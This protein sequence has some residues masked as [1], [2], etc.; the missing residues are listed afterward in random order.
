LATNAHDVAAAVLAQVGPM[1]A[2]R[3]QKLVY[4]SQAWHLALLDKPLFPDTIQAWRDGPVTGTLWDAH[5]RQRNVGVWPAGNPG[6]LDDDSAHVVALVCEVYGGL[7]GDDLSELTHSEL[8]WRNARN[9]VSDEQPSKAV[10]QH[11]AMKQFYR[12]RTLA[13]RAVADLVSGGLHGLV[14]PGLAASEQSRILAEIREEFRRELRDGE[15]GSPEPHGSA[16]HTRSDDE[17][18][19]QVKAHLNRERPQRGSAT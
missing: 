16:F 17:R 15:P 12:A 3:L 4:Y 19:P 1:E 11:E 18:P 8:P 10:I 6:R 2:M 13:G 14:S 5:S 9:G 7:S